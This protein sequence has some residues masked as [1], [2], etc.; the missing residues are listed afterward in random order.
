MSQILIYFFIAISLSMDAFSLA[1]SIGTIEINKKNL[2]KLPITI[3]IFHFFM[4]IIGNKIG[5][6]IHYKLFG[7][8]NY[9]TALIFLILAIEMK[10]SKDS[11][12]PVKIINILT[13]LFVALLVSIDSF[14]VGIAFGMNKENII[15]SSFIISVTSFFFTTIGLIIGNKL[16]EKNQNQANNIGIFIL[17][18]IS[19]KYLLFS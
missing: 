15:L 16:K 2:I 9:L 14:T 11:N 18:L 10:L 13:I 12:E 19:I 3:G 5:N 7:K 4:P 1:I 17:I 8:T 6:I